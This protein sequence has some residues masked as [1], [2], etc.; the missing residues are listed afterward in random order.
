MT[1]L[2]EYLYFQEK[3]SLYFYAKIQYAHFFPVC[4]D[5]VGLGIQCMAHTI[6]IIYEDL[7][8]MGKLLCKTK[9]LAV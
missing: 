9:T 3:F 6:K 4:D 8:F 5:S 7:V 2:L 1:A